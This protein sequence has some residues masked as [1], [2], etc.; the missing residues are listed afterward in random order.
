M[1]RR[2][3]GLHTSP[4]NA[5]EADATTASETGTISRPAWPSFLWCNVDEDLWTTRFRFRGCKL[6]NG[7]LV[8]D[9]CASGGA[10]DEVGAGRQ[11]GTITSAAMNSHA[12]WR[13]TSLN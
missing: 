8:C 2:P 9:Q 11:N 10:A 3:S 13:K 12:M 4:G 1:C 6:P 5:N 7:K